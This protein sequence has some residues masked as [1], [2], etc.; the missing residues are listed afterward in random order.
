MCPLVTSPPGQRIAWENVWTS[1]VWRQLVS[2]VKHPHGVLPALLKSHAAR[3]YGCSNATQ[4]QTARIYL[5]L[6]LFC[7]LT[8]RS[9]F[10]LLMLGSG[11]PS[12]GFSK[13]TGSS[14]SLGRRE[15]CG[16]GLRAVRGLRGLQGVVEGSGAG[17]SFTSGLLGE[18]S[19]AVGDRARLACRRK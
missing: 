14:S 5:S 3:H 6:R 8:C 15:G 17:W 18:G 13:L 9:V 7:L 12:G 16:V 10:T 11:V 2:R 19:R 4:W 1:S